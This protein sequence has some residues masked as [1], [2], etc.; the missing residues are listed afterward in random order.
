MT[1]FGLRAILHRIELDMV[2]RDCAPHL[3]STV[4]ASAMKT[5]TA[6][7]SYTQELSALDR[8]KFWMPCKFCQPLPEL[9]ENQS[10]QVQTPFITCQISAP[11]YSA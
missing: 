7:V 2:D 10:T 6:A 5:A 3:L 8:G 4:F 1:E 11:C 9:R